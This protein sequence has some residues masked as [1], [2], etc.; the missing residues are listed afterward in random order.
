FHW[1]WLER[2]GQ[3]TRPRTGRRRARQGCRDVSS[4]ALFPSEIAATASVRQAEG[5]RKR[6]LATAPGARA[7]RLNNLER[8]CY[9]PHGARLSARTVL[10]GNSG[11]HA[12]ARGRRFA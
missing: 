1:R 12:G 9:L 3:T 5:S 10:R 2:R 7:F 11:A 8:A 4:A 6:A